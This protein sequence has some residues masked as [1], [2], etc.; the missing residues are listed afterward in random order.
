MPQEAQQCG[1]GKHSVSLLLSTLPLSLFSLFLSLAR[2]AILRVI[3]RLGIT[4]RI[5]II[6][7]VPCLID[8]RYF[9]LALMMAFT[10]FMSS[11]CCAATSLSLSY[12]VLSP[13]LLSLS[14]FFFLPLHYLIRNYL[15]LPSCLSGLGGPGPPLSPFG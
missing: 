14:F 6:I 10:E 12:L 4:A 2:R 3:R 11:C 13:F 8:A 15:C 1:V 9:G 5:Q 7:L